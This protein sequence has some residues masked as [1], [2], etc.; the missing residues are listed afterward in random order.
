MHGFDRLAR[1]NSLSQAQP[2]DECKPL[3][4]RR[5]GCSQLFT[6]SVTEQMAR[7]SVVLIDFTISSSS[8]RWAFE[9]YVKHFPMTPEESQ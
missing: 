5:L 4:E 8:F 1:E 6:V 3:G 7:Y 2:F 9:K